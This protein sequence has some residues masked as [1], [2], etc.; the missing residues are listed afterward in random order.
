M[1]RLSGSGR[2]SLRAGHLILDDRHRPAG[3]VTSFAYLNEKFDFIVLA[4]VDA[5][6][7]ITPGRRVLGARA[8]E[9]PAGGV[10]E[11]KLVELTVMP[12]FPT[13]DERRGW[14]TRYA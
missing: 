2:K 13:E 5:T 3:V 7:D 14:A 12:R 4:Y 8:T 10:D 11:A 1:A 6:F 9:A